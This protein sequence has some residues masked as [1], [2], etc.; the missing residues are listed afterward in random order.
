MNNRTLGTVAMLLAPAM[1]IEALIPGGSEMPFVVGTASMLFMLG[2][3]CSHIG[4]WRIAAT[5]RS[6]WGRTVLTI[7]L[8]LV[9]LAFLFGLFEATGLVGDENI[10][11][12]ITDIAWP[13]SMLTMNLVAITAAIV[14][15]LR[16]WQRF[17][18][19]LCGL[20]LPASIILGIVTGAGMDS[21]LVGYI[22]FG[23][24]AVFWGLLGFVVR[25]SEAEMVPLVAPVRS[26]A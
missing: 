22:F 3:F 17:A 8:T 23:M 9:A 18:P 2:S 26:V 5:G 24:L 4:L 16:G 11:F 25:Q 7:Q 12:T 19:L 13:L 14:G 21:D 1:L 6:W 15:K 20:A 10:L